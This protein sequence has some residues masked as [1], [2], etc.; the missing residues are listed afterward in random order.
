MLIMHTR[1][2]VATAFLV[3]TKVS[4]HDRLNCAPHVGISLVSY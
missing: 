4:M 2:A 1:Y 3:N